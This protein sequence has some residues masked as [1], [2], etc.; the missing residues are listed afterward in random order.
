MNALLFL[1]NHGYLTI[2]FGL[3]LEYIGLP[4]PGELILVFF[5][6]L[7]YWGKLNLWLVL[8]SS[9]SAALLGDHFWYVVARRGGKKWLRWFCRVTLGSAQCETRTE[10][11]FKRYGPRSLLIEKFVPVF[12]HFAIPMAGM[13]GVPYLRFLL[14]ESLGS[15]IWLIGS[16]ELGVMMATHVRATMEWIDSFGRALLLIAVLVVLLV[17]TQR[18]RKRL[19]YGAPKVESAPHVKHEPSVGSRPQRPGNLT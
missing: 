12:R 5:G 6:A 14:Y 4:V 15:L 8:A 1:Q 11:F 19:R 16:T 3:L 13:T 9:F 10:Q 7:I 17:V 2:F 18:L